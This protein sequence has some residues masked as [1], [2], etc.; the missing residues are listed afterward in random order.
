MFISLCVMLCSGA[1]AGG[2]DKASVNDW[3]PS[4]QQISGFAGRVNAVAEKSLGTPYADSP[5]GEGPEGTHDTDPKMDLSRVDCVTFVEQTVALAASADYDAAYG[6]LQKVRYKDG[7]ETFAGRNHFLEADWLRD[8]PWCVD[9]TDKL[10]V[11]TE[12]V[13]R[14]ISRKAFFPKVNAPEL[15]QDLPDESVTVTCI[16]VGQVAAAEA[17]LPD[18]ALV[19]FVGKV[20]WL[21]ALH[22]GIFLRDASGAGHL[23]HASSKAGSVAKVSLSGYASEQSTRYMGISVHSMAEPVLED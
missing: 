2:L 12:R 20:D 6:L 11:K 23:Y 16:P 21:F 5:L 4:V 10:G 7:K 18:V 19:L 13:T 17:K 8:N 22:C 3:L 9:I 15:G 1:A 14:T